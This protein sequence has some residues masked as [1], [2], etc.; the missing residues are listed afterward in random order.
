M[1]EID[2]CLWGKDSGLPAPYSVVCHLIDTAAVAG[3]LWD[4]W[5]DEAVRGR[6][7]AEIRLSVAEM[8]AA[9]CFWAGLHDVGKISPSFQVKVRSLFD[10]LL[11]SGRYGEAAAGES[12]MPLHHSEV[13]HWVLAELLADFGYPH[14]NR[15][16]KSVAHQIGQL[17]GGHHGRFWA[18]LTNEELVAPRLHRLGMGSGDEW[19]QQCRAHVEVL[20]RLT[21]ARSAPEA[22]ISSSVAVLLAGLV[23]VADWLASQESF[24]VPRMP[25]PGRAASSKDLEE[26]WSSAVREAPGV[27][28]RAGLGRAQFQDMHFGEMFDFAPNS[29]QS[30][31]VEYLPGLVD[32]AGLLLVTAPPGDGKT[33]AA[34]WSASLMARRCGLGGVGFAMPTMA[35][36]DAMHRRVAGFAERSLAGTA[37]LTRVHGMSWLSSDA[38]GEAP[39]DASRII[40]TGEASRWLQTSL[41]GLL[42]PLSVFTIDQALTGVLPVRYNVLR[43]LGLSGKALV[44]DEAHAYGP[45]MHELL[46]VLLKWLGALRVPVVVLSATLTGASARSLVDAYLQGS[47]PKKGRERATARWEPCYPGWVYADGASGEISEPRAVESDRARSLRLVREPVRT[48]VQ[49]THADHRLAVIRK[50]LRAVVDGGGCVL[51]ICTTVA[52]AQE[53]WEFLDTW[54]GEERERGAESLPE[55]HL[56]HARFRAGDRAKRTAA[57]ESAF[58]KAGRRPRS[59]ILVGTQIVEQSFD[60]DFD[61]IITDLAPVALLLQRSGRCVRHRDDRAGVDPHAD[62]RPPWMPADP[63]VV[64]LDPEDASGKCDPPAAWRAVYHAD[65]LNATSALL[66]QYEGRPVAVPGDVQTLVDAVYDHSFSALRLSAGAEQERHEAW[67]AERLAEEAADKHLAAMVH[68]RPPSDVGTDL[69]RLSTASTPVGR[70][71]VTT[72]LGADSARVVCVYEQG[73]GH[74]T[75]DE[76]GSLEVPGWGA[77]KRL[78]RDMAKLLARFVIPVPGRWVR[79]RPELHDAVP[80]SWR[81][82]ASTRD[83]LPLVMRRQAD[84]WLGELAP[85]R[86]Q[87]GPSGLRVLSG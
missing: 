42:A 8:R 15:A 37:A 84:E 38:D 76:A 31:L 63:T 29:L 54:L 35:T 57:C 7:A 60:L 66:R 24:I 67:H 26:H 75:L 59:A 27:V 85:G 11:A 44:I 9:V 70:E 69:H 83:W 68:I 58:G 1:C 4:V 80:E 19:R 64:V 2:C 6:L 78:N 52:E 56:L 43:L 47:C 45:W 74:W 65:L 12:G 10:R 51:V 86:V 28:E 14:S 23:I 39:I 40:A 48:G 87:Y 81:A 36:V 50:R 71:L 3:A 21:G 73:S 33:E 18:K 17:L 25:A 41:R 79:G 22:P 72:R 34:W 77:K 30:S 53:T 5:F 46:L 49:T 20:Q 61:L 13:T 82:N 32:G 16:R 55:L 62:R